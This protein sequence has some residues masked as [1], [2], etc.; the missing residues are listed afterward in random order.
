MPKNNSLFK[1]A[2]KLVMKA[3]SS[4]NSN[5]A[6]SKSSGADWRSLLQQAA[7]TLASQPASTD[8]RR[9]PVGSAPAAKVW[10]APLSRTDRA[11]I[12]HYDYL[13]KTA[14]PAALERIHQE[15][16]ARLT[17]QQRMAVES[18]MRQ[19]LPEA[20]RPQSSTP[21]DLA[22][23]ASRAEGKRPGV[24]RGLLARAG[25]GP[26][27][28]GAVMAGSLLVGVAGGALMSLA[29]A[30]LLE[31]AMSQGVDFEALAGAVDLAAIS[32]SVEGFA[33][34]AGEYASGVGEQATAVGDSFQNLGGFSIRDFFNR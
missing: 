15:A 10:S 7:K 31:Q 17:P 19:E 33:S 11:A 5:K 30:P 25:G 26:G 14:S 21:N 27:T 29:A 18:R 2:T 3:M 23:A 28:A 13:V 22:S 6:S 9:Q 16:F 24:M 12:A 8:Q 34:G 20:D 32:G 4:N 1:L